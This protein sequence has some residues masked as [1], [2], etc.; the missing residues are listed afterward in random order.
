MICIGG[1]A[2]IRET[3]PF[4]ASLGH[5]SILVLLASGIPVNAGTPSYHSMLT[6]G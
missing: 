2:L 3:N 4:S 6:H 5:M 1:Y